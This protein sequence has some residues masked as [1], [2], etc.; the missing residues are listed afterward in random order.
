[1]R[2]LTGKELDGILVASV[3]GTLTRSSRCRPYQMRRSELVSA[4]DTVGIHPE[5]ELLLSCAHMRL[6]AQSAAR[7]HTLLRADLD[8][9]SL[10]EGALW[11][12]V[13]PLLYRSVHTIGTDTV[14]LAVVERLQ[15]YCAVNV[16]RNLFLTGELLKLLHL[17]EAQGIPALPYKGPVLAAAVYGNL[18]LRQFGDLDILVPR[19]A[20]LHARALLLDQ[21]YQSPIPM[22]RAQE[23]AHL[24][25]WYNFHLVRRDM[26]LLVE[27]HW[28]ITPRMGAFPLDFAALWHRRQYVAIAGTTVAHFHP[29][30]V[31]L[32]LCVHGAKDGW[33]RLIWLCD[34]A[35][36]LRVHPELE[37]AQ[38]LEQARAL[39]STRRLWLGLGLAQELLG[40]ALPTAVVHR[41][42]ADPVLPS[43]VAQVQAGLFRVTASRRN[44]A[45]ALR[46]RE[47]WQ[48]R[49][50]YFLYYAYQKMTPNAKDRAF[51]PVPAGLSFLSY[52][53]RPVR[54]GREYGLRVLGLLKYFWQDVLSPTVW[55]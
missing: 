5:A 21:G 14:P 35:E 40:T 46:V 10:V 4:K 29:V 9:S 27:L 12:G 24:R 44:H 47:C 3:W 51:L 43:L 19:Q 39:R 6:D 34:I 25:S 42:H 36:L 28:G 52:L 53:C 26:G 17:L 45:F 16:R 20:V 11:H 22:T 48:D 54:V 33:R 7:I 49:V 32:L 31:L 50:G 38:V 13:M 41:M 37:W 18:A 15:D 23:A 2:L 55:P 1:V 8:W 30:D